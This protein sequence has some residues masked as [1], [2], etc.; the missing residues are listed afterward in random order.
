ME[1]K[2]GPP[3]ILNKSE[4]NEI[5]QWIEEMAAA[6]FPVTIEELL[7]SVQCLIKGL[8]RQNPF[9]NDRPGNSWIKGFFSRNPT[10]SKRV[11]QN[12]TISRAAVTSANIHMWFSEVYD[13]LK[14]NNFEIILDDPS[15]IFNCDETA[16]F[17]NPKGNK[18]L[19]RKGCKTVYQQINSDEK[20]CVTALLT[21]SASDIVAPTVVLFKYKRIPQEI[22]DNFPQRWGLGKSDSGWMTCE[23]F[24]EFIADIFYPW[25]VESKATFPVI[26][27]IDGHASHFS[28]QTSQFCD[29]NGIILVALY[30]NATH[31]L[32]PMDVAVFRTLKENWKKK[33]HEWRI[34][35]LE[36]PV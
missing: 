33:V 13:Y 32:Q 16:F 11:A 27:F 31:L 34:K 1:R 5:R 23:A 15:R 22:A 14:K 25:L 20:E 21:A 36:N 7:T 26:L 18:V 28:L 35:N 9:K 17:L 10:I 2:M 3:P 4:E 12:L 30:P 24:F 6:G 29:K 8:K 19:A